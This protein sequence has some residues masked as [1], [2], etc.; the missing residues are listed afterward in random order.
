MREYRIGRLNGSFVVTWS[1]EGR[2]RRYRLD[3]L[4]AKEAEAEAIYVIRRETLPRGA[5]T[6]TDL[7]GAYRADRKG[8]PVDRNMRSSGNAVL[9]HFGHLRPDQITTEMC[10]AYTAARKKA[11]SQG[12]I[13]TELGHLRTCLSWAVKQR[14]ISSAPHIE[15][16]AKPAPRERY[17]THAE[18]ARLLDADCEPHIKL[19]ITVLLTTAARVGAVLEL[20]WDRVD[21]QRGQIR[22]RVDAEGPRKGRATVPING[23]LRAART[24]ARA[25]AVSDHVI[26][27]AGGPVKSIRK[28]FTRAVTSAKLTGVT[29]HTLR[30]SAAVHMAEAGVPMDEI[31]QYLGHSN[32]QITANVYARFSPQHLSRAAEALEFGRLRVVK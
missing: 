30:H 25:A 2:R 21:L 22:L 32:V 10:R 19:A 3:A 17:L 24:A 31:S 27:W 15:R 26:E 4:T 7:W 16:P 9:P 11:I 18:V 20:T 23:T 5:L 28:G 29:L 12:S 1:D 6:V 14:L 8:R 13:W